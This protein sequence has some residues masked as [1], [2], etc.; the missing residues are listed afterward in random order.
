MSPIMDDM[1]LFLLLSALAWA[2]DD[3]DALAR[4]AVDANPGLAAMEARTAALAAAAEVADVWPDP[5]AS[6]EL[7]N[8]PLGGFTLSDHPM[9]GVQLRVQQPLP[10]PGER[11]RR[12]EVAELSVEYAALQQS[13][14][15]LDLRHRVIDTWWRLALT[16]MLAGITE[17][18]LA[19]LDEL[20][21]TV[22]ARYRVDAVGQ[23]AVLRVTLLRDRLSDELGDF[24]RA[25]QQLTAALSAALS[26]PRAFE[27]PDAVEPLP[28]TGTVEGWLAAAEAQ[29]PALEALRVEARQ[30]RA[31]AELA[32]VQARPSM[33]LWAGYRARTWPDDGGVDLVSGGVAVPVPVGSR[34]RSQGLQA[35][36]E[37]DARAAEDRLAAALDTLRAEL[38]TLHAAWDRAFAKAGTYRDTLLPAAQA[39]REATLADFQVGRADFA[40]V[41]QAEVELLALERA[42]RIAAVETHLRAAELEALI[43]TR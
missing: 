41:Y 14:A 3:V 37:Q 30:A 35:A 24:A 18:E 12:S 32:R 21:E 38:T 42:E 8:L 2:A 29:H 33:S 27:T 7:S 39:V 4:A 11:A 43:A 17:V 1:T 22:Q 36:A 34:A 13:A 5:V 31:R 23:H 16:R 6:V 15:A 10:A 19:R 9:A 20:A 28:L 25:D 26:A 40:A